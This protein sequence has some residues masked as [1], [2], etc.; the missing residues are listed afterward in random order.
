MK[1]KLL[2][3]LPLL[4][5]LET[6]I[7]ASLE[8]QMDAAI[9]A[10]NP[11][12]TS[13]VRSFADEE[14]KV[15]ERIQFLEEKRGYRFKK[16]DFQAF[17][18]GELLY[19]KADVDGVAYATTSVVRHAEGAVGDVNTHYK[20]RTPHFNY[21][22]GFRVGLGVESPFDLF[23][24]C[25][26][27][28]RFYTEGHD[29]AHGTLV[30]FVPIPGDKLIYDGIGLIKSMASIPNSAS[31]DCG[32][33]E[34]ILDLQLARGIPVSRHFFMR[35]YFGV[36]SLWSSIDW[37]IKVKR[38]FLAPGIFDQDATELKVKNDFQA[39]GGLIGL[40]FDWKAPM[41]F[42]VNMRGSGSLVWGR[43]EELTK[44]KYVFVPAGTET[45][46]HQNYK[47]V[48][49]FHSLKGLWELFV[50]VFWETDFTSK[51]GEKPMLIR[52]KHKHH[53][54]LRLLAGYEYQHWPWFGQKTNT[55][56]N[57]E[58]DRFSLGFQGFTGGAKLVF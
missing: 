7:E 9:V 12:A 26:V 36:R 29:K 27:W 23:D 15:E 13:N 47:A 5:S 57:R 21:D 42:G 1:L 38:N 10:S 50:G 30:S 43:A 44:Q 41:G 52:V 3:L 35:P 54:S 55:Q 49:S 31:A 46:L 56:V 40:E 32:I 19:W 16:R 33:K 18:E 2:L 14:L 28:T 53:V 25:F 51:K 48:N 22:P 6:G 37:D 58:R 11:A 34:N 17:A 45:K 24:I 20:T 39:V 4:L 8:T